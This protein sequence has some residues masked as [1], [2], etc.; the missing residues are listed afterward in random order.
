MRSVPRHLFIPDRAWCHPDD[1]P[2]YLIDRAADPGM[3]LA[4]A[5][6]DAVIVTRIDD[7]MGDMR[8]PIGAFASSVSAPGIVAAALSLLDPFDGDEVLEIGTGTGWT[9]GLLARRLGDENVTSIETDRLVFAEA[10]GNLKRSGL[11][12]RLLLGD[13]ARGWPDGALYDRVHVTRGVREVPHP[14]VEQTRPGGLIVLP[15]TPRW[16]GGHLLRL[17]AAGDG[18]AVG[19]FHRGV[20]AMPMR[21]QRLVPA[22]VEGPYRRS[23]THLDPRRVVRSSAGADVAV[24]GSL[25]DVYGTHAGEEDGG[26]RLWLWSGDSEA[27]VH[28]APGYKQSSVFHRGPRDLWAEVEAAYLRWVSWGAPDRDRF[29]MTVTPA[30]Q[31]IWL[32][33]PGNPLM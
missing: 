23:A 18:T 24:A 29:G 33:S 9:A 21:S 25:P 12:P 7:G 10:A 20:A 26:F 16:E 6:S 27:Q 1:G 2:G 32:D 4:A 31:H 8:Q 28:R 5:Y 15:W 17:T 13:G 19:R 3:W 11:S 14:W 30:G 22:Q